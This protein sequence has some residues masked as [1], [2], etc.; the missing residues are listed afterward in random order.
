LISFSKIKEMLGFKTKDSPSN[1][2]DLASIIQ[3]FKIVEVVPSTQEH[4]PF[5][6]VTDRSLNDTSEFSFAD[7]DPGLFNYDENL[8]RTYSS[9]VGTKVSSPVVGDR[10]AVQLKESDPRFGEIGSSSPSPYTSGFLKKEYNRDLEGIEGLKIYNKMRSD[11]VIAGSLFLFKTPVYAAN[12]FMEP[13]SQENPEDKIISDFVWKCLTKYMSIGWTQVKTESMLACEFG[14]YMFEKV[15]EKR[16]IDGVNRIV[17]QKLAPRHPM[18][19]KEN[20]WEFDSHGGPDSVT[21]YTEKDAT[22]DEVTIPISKLLVITLNKEAN[23]ITGRSMLRP[24]YKHWYYKEQLYKIDAIQKERHGIGVPVI[25]LP[26]NFGEA[27]KIAANE[28]GRN[29]RTNERAHVV[30][31]P[32]WEVLFAKLEGQP[33]DSIK[34]IEMHDKAIRESIL[35]AFLA[36]DT[37]TKEEDVALFLKASRF[38]ADSICDAFNL[39]LI[40]EL[41]R[42]NFGKDAKVPTLRV[43]RIGEQADWRVMSFAIRSMVGAGIIRPDDVLEAR[44]RE[45]MDLPFADVATTRVVQTPQAGPT[46]PATVPNAVPGS[47]SP[48][49]PGTPTPTGKTDGTADGTGLPRQTPVASAKLPGGNSGADKGG[50]S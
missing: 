20:G 40:P 47:G 33:V 43:R 49:Q 3:R 42:Y 39:Y 27:E 5:V 26:P 46:T 48:T 25:K 32:G 31:P 45:E 22:I 30:L 28:L 15:W 14:Y 37:A 4:G 18:D 35:A 11:G 8:Q 29:L 1:L 17:L 2:T 50:Q 23:D 6:I 13:A 16:K 34:S 9:L 24:M 38:V 41:V 21:M 44:M 36:S 10:A 12:W 7:P 19:V